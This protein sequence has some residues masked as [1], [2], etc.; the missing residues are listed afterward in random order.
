MNAPD[1]TPGDLLAAALRAP[2]GCPPLP[3]LAAA[4]T[5]ELAGEELAEI[6]RHAL[7]CASCAPGSLLDRA[8]AI[9][10]PGLGRGAARTSAP[11]RL[12]RSALSAALAARAALGL[13][14]R[15]GRLRVRAPL[16]PGLAIEDDEVEPGAVAGIE[17]ETDWPF[18][19]ES[20]AVDLEIDPAL[21]REPPSVVASPNHGAVAIEGQSWEAGTGRFRFAFSSADASLDAEIPGA[22]FVVLVPTVADESLLGQSFPLVLIAADTF[23]VGPGAT[24]LATE[25]KDGLLLFDANAETEHVYGDGF[26]G[27]SA[28]GWSAI[29]GGGS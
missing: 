19:I 7:A 12:A 29:A 5:G 16:E 1:R 27:G 17:I 24:P 15:P 4:G 2:G 21:V 9:L 14:P 25:L 3:R 23:L 13:A 8:C 18:A 22:L 11:R 28:W 20:G 6:E 10:G 26:A